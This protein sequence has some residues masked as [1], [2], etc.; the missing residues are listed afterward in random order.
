MGYF[1]DR[2]KNE[3]NTATTNGYLWALSLVLCGIVTLIEHH[4][5]FFRTWRKGMQI[6]TA[7]IAAIY[8]K[9]HRLSSL[10][11]SHVP[12][13]GS[14]VNLATNDVERFLSAALFVSYLFWGP[15]YGIVVLS[16]GIYLVG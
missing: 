2:E 6:R 5:V 9:S 12:T 13:A 10:G 14:I 3:S 16:V 4:H 1:S 15:M 7:A 11:G 8:A